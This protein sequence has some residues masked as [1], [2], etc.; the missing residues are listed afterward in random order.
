MITHPENGS[1]GRVGIRGG[2]RK[3]LRQP[4]VLLGKTMQIIDRCIVL[5]R[6]KDWV[7][8]EALGK[9]EFIMH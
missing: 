2:R 3:D 8:Y 1:E 6:G 4:H 5:G 7:I 9:A